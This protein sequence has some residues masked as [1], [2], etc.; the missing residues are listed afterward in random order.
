MHEIERISRLLS[1][2]YWEATDWDHT[3]HW[4]LIADLLLSRMEKMG[5]IVQY[6]RKLEFC[7]CDGQ[8]EYFFVHV[9]AFNQEQEN[10]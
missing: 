2:R 4:G 10:G 9:R 6:A 1:D 7:D 8:F 5:K 3:Y